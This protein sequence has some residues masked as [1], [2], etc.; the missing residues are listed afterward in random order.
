MPMFS[1]H[2][3]LND[4]LLGLKDKYRIT[5]TQG[6]MQTKIIATQFE[7]YQPN[8]R[9]DTSIDNSIQSGHFPLFLAV[10]RFHTNGTDPGDWYVGASGENLML[11]YQYTVNNLDTII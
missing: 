8:W 6:Y 1:P 3:T 10:S 5:S 11:A 9:T 7:T 2:N 4:I